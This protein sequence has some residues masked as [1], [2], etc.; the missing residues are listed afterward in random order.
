MI[1]YE[2][3]KDWILYNPLATVNDLAEAKAAVLSLKTIP[4]QR[5]WADT[6]QTIQ[7]KREIAGTS[8]IEGADFTDAE[9]DV[10]VRS[11]LAET[12]EQMKTRSQ[13][14]AQAAVRAYKWIEKLPNDRAV[15]AE[16]IKEV[17]RLIITGADDDHC[18]PGVIRGRDNNVIFG[19]PPHRG[20]DGGDECRAAFER[21]GEAIQ[22]EFRGHDILI[23]ALALHYHFA[24]IHPFLDGNGRTARAVEALMLQRAGLKDAL[25]IAM[26]NYYYDEKAGYLRALG[27]VRQAR[28]DLTPFLIFGL[29]GIALQCGRLFASIKTH[30]SKALFR[31][32]M[33]DL[34]NRLMTT[35]KRVIARRQM[36]IL[37]LLLEADDGIEFQQL[38]RTT[39]ASYSSL[40]NPRRALIRDLSYLIGVDAVRLEVIAPDNRYR[41]SINLDWP[42]KITEGEFFDRVKQ[43][44]R[45]KSLPFL[46]WGIRI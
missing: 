45:A 8:K 12:A 24:A 26:S 39:D 34:F 23:Q 46:Q 29:R 2:L 16:L 9:L 44:P 1:K 43:Y 36:G 27:D 31:S 13:R 7:L 42:T 22:R 3:P 38:I 4:F 30:V 37:N 33:M 35:K 17:H 41:I 40:K 21:L 20:A 19:S 5:S 15:D 18:E 28:H 6:M 10:A 32:V 11:A 25:F 14:Q